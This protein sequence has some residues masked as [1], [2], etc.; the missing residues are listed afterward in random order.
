LKKSCVKSDVEGDDW[1]ASAPLFRL[2]IVGVTI[3][4]H[5]IFAVG[6]LATRAVSELTTYRPKRFPQNLGSFFLIPDFIFGMFPSSKDFNSA[7]S[8]F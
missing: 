4:V 8:Y 6:Q 5:V 3:M 1:H 7:W 2:A